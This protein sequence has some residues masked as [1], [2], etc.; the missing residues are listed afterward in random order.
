MSDAPLPRRSTTL[1]GFTMLGLFWGAWASVLPSVQDATDLSKGALGVALLFVSVGS[2]PAMFFIAGPLVARFGARAAAY[3]AAAFAAAT[4][5][6][7]LAGSFPTLVVALAAA[8]ATSGIFDVAVNAN[9]GRIESVTGKRLMPLAHGLYSVGILVGAVTAGVA[10][11]A[12][13]GREPILLAVSLLVLLT[14]IAAAGDTARVHTE[15]SRA[16]RLTR[17]LVVIGLLGAAAFVVEGGSESWSALF[18]ARVH[19][20]SPTVSGLGPGVFGASMAAGRF[21][22]Q[23]AGRVGDRALLVGGAVVGMTGCTLAAVSLDAWVALVGLAIGG[24]GVSL[25]APIIFGLAGRRPDAATAV[26]TVTTLGY[27]GLLV[28]PPLVGLVA[29]VSS[30]RVSFIVLAAIAAAVAAVAPRVVGAQKAP[31]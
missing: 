23:A 29:Q 8:G 22:G 31:A 15:Q 5:L 13:A 9:A 19:D 20:A 1:A 24:A 28:G 10:R 14:A 21:F 7:G 11:G 27:L 26:A 25:N 12:G 18:L 30:L 3:G 17:P 4:T 6:P 2:V 16:M